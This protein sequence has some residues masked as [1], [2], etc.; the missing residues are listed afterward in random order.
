M[1][2]FSIIVPLYNKELSIRTTIESILKQTY[3]HFELIIINDGSTDRSLEIAE[4]FTD[5]RISIVDVPNGGVSNARNI[6]ISKAS[7]D[8][9]TFLDADDLWYE[10]SLDEFKF[11]IDNFKKGQV[12]FTSH[13][14]NIKSIQSREKRYYID[15][16][17]WWR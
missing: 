10:N 1:I 14:L 15:T 11:L 4:Q 16:L 2:K 12:F 3:P 5:N 7:Y 13:S 17:W 8:Y 9:L 6:G